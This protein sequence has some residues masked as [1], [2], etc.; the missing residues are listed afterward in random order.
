MRRIH[1]ARGRTQRKKNRRFPSVLAT[2]VIAAGPEIWFDN[3]AWE[4]A[5]RP[6]ALLNLQNRREDY[7]MGLYRTWRRAAR[8]RRRRSEFPKELVWMVE[9]PSPT[10][11][12]QAA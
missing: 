12:G 1:T 8:E 11:E 5:D 4:L 2:R 6:Q 10:P 7:V 3:V 9:G